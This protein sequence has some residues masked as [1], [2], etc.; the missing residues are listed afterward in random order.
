[1]S[2]RNDIVNEL[3]KPTRKKF[4]HRPVKLL[5]VDDLFQMDLL[6]VQQLAK[7]NNKNRFILTAINCFTKKA[8]AVP[9]HSK[10]SRD[11]TTAVK[12]VLDQATFKPRHIC[13]DA[14]M[15]FK[16]KS[17]QQV[18]RDRGINHY[19]AYSNVKAQIVERWNRTLRN[20][21]HK[22][23]AMRGSTKWVSHL[24]NYVDQY[25]NTKHSK[26]KMKPNEVLKKHEKKL[27]QTVYNYKRP[28]VKTKFKINDQVRV[29]SARSPFT[30]GYWPSW[31]INLYRVMKINPKKPPTYILA[32]AHD[33]TPVYG[34]FYE[35]EMLKTKNPDTYLISRV[36]KRKGSKAY[37]EWH[38]T[39]DKSWVD[40]KTISG[41]PK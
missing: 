1:M 35:P 3:Y 30:K 34:S 8:Y 27:L 36:L 15:E 5:G 6:D 39:N 21:M 37:V 11:M 33:A 7:S 19:I 40:A 14:G 13:T 32:D 12:K 4:E 24:Q 29:S 17:V 18:F 10:T 20:I 28:I 26:T 38:G 22:D 23:M 16:N 2:E 31:S 25:N 9:I 41:I